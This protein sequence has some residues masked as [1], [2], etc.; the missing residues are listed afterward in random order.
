[1][2]LATSDV[3]T[4]A[5]SLRLL[6]RRH[7]ADRA[8]D[9]WPVH[10][11]RRQ[12]LS[13]AARLLASG[14]AGADGRREFSVVHPHSSEPGLG[15]APGIDVV[16]GLLLPGESTIQRRHN[17]SSLTMCLAGEGAAEIDDLTFEV[18]FRDVWIT[19]SMSDHVLRNRGAEPLRYAIYS[20]RPL[21]Q[22]LEIYYHDA[23]LPRRAAEAAVPGSESSEPRAKDLA[24]GFP[25]GDGSSWLLPYEHLI[26]PE[27]NESK[28]LL[29]RWTDVAPHLG[30]LTSLTTGYTGRPLVCLYNPATGARNGTTPSFFATISN[31]SPNFIGPVHRHSSAAINFILEGSGWSIVDGV[32]IDWEAG[33][34]MLSAPGW[35]PHGHARGADGASI[36]TVQD[37][38]LQIATESLVW[39]ED[40]DGGPILS[41]GKQAGFQTNLRDF[42]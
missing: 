41:L 36:L 22:K 27:Y 19:P 40:I 6:D 26:D 9:R 31:G 5:T 34:I 14:P 13:E 28:P 24:P 21:L 35:A 33:D 20:N 3:A 12:E 2:E 7:F 1:M 8:N 10:I 29:W 32:R 18:T 42:K 38:P 37:H 30:M 15:L 23:G 25:I 11:V 4:N 39:Q 17:A 16:F